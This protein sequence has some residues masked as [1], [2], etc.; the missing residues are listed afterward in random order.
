VRRAAVAAVGLACGA[1]VWALSVPITGLREP[2]DAPV[3]YYVAMVVAGAV[4]AW[5]APR[6]WW[7][8]VIAIFVGERVYAFLMLPESRPWLLV[9]VVVNVLIATWLPSA[10]GAAGVFVMRRP[11]TPRPMKMRGRMVVVAL[12]AVVLVSWYV[13]A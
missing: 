9:G 4:A 10:I 3:F 8:A 11:A 7:L 12:A 5:P 6:Y 13:V 2:F 1:A